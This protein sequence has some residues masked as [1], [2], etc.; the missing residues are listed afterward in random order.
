MNDDVYINDLKQSY[1]IINN[2][3]TITMLKCLSKSENSVYNTGA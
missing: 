2:T 1:E 3:N